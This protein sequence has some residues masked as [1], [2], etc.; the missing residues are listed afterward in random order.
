MGRTTARTVRDPLR[1][2]GVR[3]EDQSPLF[4]VAVGWRF[5]AD[6]RKAPTSA[7]AGSSAT[8]FVTSSWISY[9]GQL[10]WTLRPA[11]RMTGTRLC[12]ADDEKSCATGRALDCEQADDV[13]ANLRARNCVRRG[14]RP[15]DALQR[16]R[17]P[18]CT[19]G[20]SSSPLHHPRL[21]P[22][23]LIMRRVFLVKQLA[24][25]TAR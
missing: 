3:S 19:V 13:G 15:R 14:Q 24:S 7:S 4:T 11:R 9:R 6:P 17:P 12:L 10:A 18:A 5:S 23:H 22:H 20:V 8:Q 21:P 16:P 2:S 25:P 1:L